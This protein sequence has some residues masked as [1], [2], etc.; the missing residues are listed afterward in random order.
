MCPDSLGDPAKEEE[1]PATG[2]RA[3]DSAEGISKAVSV[4]DSDSNGG[5]WES[6]QIRIF[7]VDGTPH[8][9]D[10]LDHSVAGTIASQWRYQWIL[11]GHQGV[12]FARKEAQ[13]P[14]VAGN[15][16]TA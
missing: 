4:C 7:L 6:S 5:Q 3:A 15:R 8:P 11:Y 9:A 16:Q 2:K 14:T 12:R 10:S 13:Q 1:T